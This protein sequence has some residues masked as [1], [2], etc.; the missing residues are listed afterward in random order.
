MTKIQKNKDPERWLLRRRNGQGPSEATAALFKSERAGSSGPITASTSLGPGGRRLKT[1]DSGSAG[2]FGDDDEDGVDR[3]R[4]MERELGAEGDLD[5]LDFEETFQDDEEKMEPDDHDDEEAKELEER[6][7]REYK[8]ANKQREGYI[9]ES[10]DEEETT[11]TRAGKTLQKTLQKLEKDG[12]YDDSDEDENP[13]ISEE[14]EEEEEP[15]PVQTGPAIIA[16][17]PKPGRTP[18]QPPASNAPTN[19]AK[20]VAGSQP[21]LQIKTEPQV[22]SLSRPTSPIPASHGGHSVVAK[23]ATSP[24]VP[25]MKLSPSRATS[26]LVGDYVM[27]SG[28]GVGTGSRAGSPVSPTSPMSPSSPNLNGGAPSAVVKS[29]KRKATDDPSAPAKSKK[30]RAQGPPGGVEL[31]DRMVIEWLRNTPD[32]TTKDCIHHF[33]PYLT[34]EVKKA[35]FIALVKEV[36]Q[37]SKGVL[38]LRPAFRGDASPLPTLASA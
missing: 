15:I 6:L 11:L 17:E 7:K 35:R 19:G 29:A 28:G 8:T 34:D 26:P 2:L 36:A 24:K 27:G 12:G 25:K 22:D 37:L 5:E 30:R 31:E 1:V 3:K 33:T 20:P 13:Y 14:E 18:S 10:D 4:K 21:P 9:D 23:R 38:V 32:A 16:P